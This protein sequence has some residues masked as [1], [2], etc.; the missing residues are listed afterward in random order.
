MGK[1]VNGSVVPVPR[2]RLSPSL[3]GAALLCNAAGIAQAS[4]F[5]SGIADLRVRWDDTIEYSNAF[6][7]QARSDAIM[8]DFRTDDGD[9]NFAAGMVSNRIDLLSELDLSYQNFG[10]RVSGAAWYDR[11]YL[12]M[13]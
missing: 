11:V 3:I 8:A 9:R 12:E 7:L 5:D 2:L 6:R 4:Q 13:R 10:A 1:I